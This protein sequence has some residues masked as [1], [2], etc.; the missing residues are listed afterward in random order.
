MAVPF[1]FSVGDIIAGVKLICTSLEALKESGGAEVSHRG[2]EVELKSLES[3]LHRADK[4]ELDAGLG[5]EKVAL[6]EAI[7]QCRGTVSTFW[8]KTEKY[9]RYLQPQTATS[10][11]CGTQ[12][13]N[14]T[15]GNNSL[16]SHTSS[17]CIWNGAKKSWYKVKWATLKKDDLA[18]FRAEIRGHTSSITIMLLSMQL[19]LVR[20]ESASREMHRVELL[21][22][23]S[24]LRTQMCDESETS[25]IR[26][27][28]GKAERQ[29]LLDKIQHMSREIETLAQ[30]ESD[31][32]RTWTA[33]S[34][35]MSKIC[36]GIYGMLTIISGTVAS[37][38]EQG[39]QLLCTSVA[40]VQGNLKILARL[41]ALEA[42]LLSIPGQ[43]D[44][45]D[46]LFFIDPFNKGSWID[47]NMIDSS[48]ALIA[49]LTIKF[50]ALGEDAG[51]LAQRKF[52]VQDTATH[53]TLDIDKPWKGLFCAGQ[54]V[55]MDMVIHEAIATT[56]CPRCKTDNANATFEDTTW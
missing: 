19:K 22:T 42:L 5:L 41:Q 38:A 39:R 34:L 6:Q 46:L 56:T 23:L 36:A 13:P 1:G 4:L 35:S 3:A 51:L 43:V 27:A 21:N 9:H 54:K 16:A 12:I 28:D 31:N 37:S 29:R 18:D 25:K 50:N 33:L 8:S 20:L 11:S 48:D 45:T 15:S 2:L 24:S 14:P 17:S 26:D 47:L 10:S 44:R 30:M 49:V 52:V 32:N 7:N 40:V 53:V 55:A